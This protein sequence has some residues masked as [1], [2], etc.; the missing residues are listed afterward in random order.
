M[1]KRKRQIIR[2]ARQLFIDQGYNHTSIMDII[3]VANIS[4]GTF[5]NHFTSKNECLI[6]IL[7]EARE[8]ATNRRY[9]V[10]MN[11]DLSDINVLVEQI[12]LLMYVNR[13]HN[14]IQIF[15]SIA[16][17]TDS[18]IKG[19]LERHFIL[20][21][22][23]LSNRFIDIFGEKSKNI[24]TELAVYAIGMMQGI[25]R[26]YI[27]ATGKPA[28]PERVIR[29]VIKNIE[30]IASHLFEKQD[31][32]ITP[33]ISKALL[34]KVNE[35]PVSKEHIICQLNGFINNLSEDDSKKGYEYASFLLKELET[36]IESN[37]IFEAV[38]SAFNRTF[39]NTTHEAEAHQ[40]AIFIWRYLDQIAKQ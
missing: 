6:A 23:W 34:N 40:I 28:S 21:I 1:N 26:T 15:E 14:L 3:A 2:A 37:S 22:N 39:N 30:L 9:E 11:K 25:L 18:E 32:I 29:S 31:L 10:A 7:E 12:S 38:L 24:S 27:V 8:E 33:E 4:K 5:Y 35:M 17:S 16:G 20:E 19:V 36:T 13:E